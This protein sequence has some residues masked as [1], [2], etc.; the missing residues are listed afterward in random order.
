[1]MGGMDLFLLPKKELSFLHSQSW[2]EV[3]SLRSL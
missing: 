1:M 2:K 3:L